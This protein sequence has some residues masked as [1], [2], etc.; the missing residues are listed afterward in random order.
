MAG[1]DSLYVGRVEST[2]IHFYWLSFLVFGLFEGGVLGDYFIFSI[3]LFTYVFENDCISFDSVRFL[4]NPFLINL[5]FCNTC[6]S[7]LKGYQHLF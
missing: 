2:V 5:V 6:H 1:R 7:S 4:Y 3:C